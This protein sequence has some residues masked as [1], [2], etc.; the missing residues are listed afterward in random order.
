MMM[1]CEGCVVNAIVR[2]CSFLGVRCVADWT[3]EMSLMC[4]MSGT[5]AG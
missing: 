5:D 4:W 2:G 3:E 1:C